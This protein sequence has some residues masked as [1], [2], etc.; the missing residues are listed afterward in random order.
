MTAAAGRWSVNESSTELSEVLPSAERD[1]TMPACGVAIPEEMPVVSFISFPS[2]QPCSPRK[3]SSPPSSD[4]LDQ[5]P[6]CLLNKVF[7]Q[8]TAGTHASDHPPEV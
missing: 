5:S 4:S 8:F 7:G 3:I 1:S 6:R 2:R